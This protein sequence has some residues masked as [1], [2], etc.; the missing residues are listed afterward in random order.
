LA[1]NRS[2]TVFLSNV[3]NLFRGSFYLAK[4][5]AFE[6]GGEVLKLRKCP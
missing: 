5:K 1:A 3:E 6:K 2:K 4:R